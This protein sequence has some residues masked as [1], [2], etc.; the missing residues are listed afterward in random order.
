M[1]SVTGLQLIVA[2]I[3]EQRLI[4]CYNHKMFLQHDFYSVGTIYY[5]LQFIL[6]IHAESRQF[7]YYF[8]I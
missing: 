6:M 1:Y 3:P 4:I 5:N 2:H 7:F 8:P